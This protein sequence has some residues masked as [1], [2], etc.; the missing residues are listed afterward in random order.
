MS[1]WYTVSHTH[2]LKK[3]IRTRKRERT[4]RP[5]ENVKKIGLGSATKN[6]FSADVLYYA[7]H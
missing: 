4:A 1:S 2:T 5:S 7:N 6:S 3:N